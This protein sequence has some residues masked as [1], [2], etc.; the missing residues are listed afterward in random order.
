MTDFAWL[1]EAPGPMYMTVKEIG[2]VHR[3]EWVDDPNGAI[4]FFN[5]PHADAVMMAV[6]ESEPEL[7]AFARNL[8]EARPV[9]HGFILADEPTA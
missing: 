2:H 3:F 6:R 7:F 1:I 9:E 8:R 4:R 5:R